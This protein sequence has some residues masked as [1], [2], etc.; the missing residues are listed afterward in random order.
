MI[1]AARLAA[2]SSA[3]V[4]PTSESPL[5]VLVLHS[6]IPFPVRLSVSTPMVDSIGMQGVGWGGGCAPGFAVEG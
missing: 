1:D 6:F 2:D 5:S 3:A 4:L